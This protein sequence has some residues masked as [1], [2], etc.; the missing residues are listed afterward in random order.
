MIFVSTGNAGAGSI[1][2][3]SAAPSRARSSP[4]VSPASAPFPTRFSSQHSH[5]SPSFACGSPGFPKRFTSASPPQIAPV[6]FGSSR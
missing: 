6:S 3:I 5:D 1:G 2:P 4:S